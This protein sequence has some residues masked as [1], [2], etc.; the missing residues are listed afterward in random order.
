MGIKQ[1]FEES[2]KKFKITK[3]DDHPTNKDLKQLTHE[4]RAMLATIPTTNSGGDHRHIGMVLD[5][6][7]CVTSL[8]GTNPF[9]V[10]KNPSPFLT[11]VSTNEADCLHQIAERK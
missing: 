2:L 8:T 10:P 6:A 3:I 1:D 4:L 5:K 7:K 9:T 11:S